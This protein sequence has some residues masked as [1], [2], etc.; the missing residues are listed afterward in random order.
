MFRFDFIS[1]TYARF[2]NLLKLSLLVFLFSMGIGSII[3]M[4]E[5]EAFPTIFDGFWWAVVT[6][7]TVGYGDFVPESF[8]GRLLGLFL[9]ILGIAIFSFFIT[10]LSSSTVLNAQEKQRGNVSFHRSG[11][12]L[13]VGWNERSRQLILELQKVEPETGIVL[14]DETL[15]AKPEE[16]KDG[17]FVKGSPT[18]DET[19]ERANASEAHTAIITANLHI[20]EKS[21]DANT[22]LTLLT[23]KGINPEIYTIVEM[24][25]ARQLK[26]IERAGA[27]EIIQSSSHI[28]S[29]VI[30]GVLFHGMTDVISM[31]MKHRH[32][33]QLYFMPLPAH[34]E[35]STFKT[36]IEDRQTMDCFLLGIRRGSETILHPDKESILQPEDQLIFLKRI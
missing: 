22:V 1:E 31:I 14:I 27:D 5:P 26:N 9:I 11:H 20:D 19:F 28:S 36:A 21:A 34:L 4:L 2:H 7:S 24:I 16:L 30:N 29:L 6:V 13:V 18:L 23:V 3:H 32:E 15:Q 17:T 35:N 12:Y 10:N 8:F 25:T 33:D